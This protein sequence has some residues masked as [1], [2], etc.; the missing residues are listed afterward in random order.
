MRSIVTGYGTLSIE[1][2]VAG[3][4]LAV[5][6]VFCGVIYGAGIVTRPAARGGRTAMPSVELIPCP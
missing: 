2:L 1:I 6:L 3:I 4:I 5:L